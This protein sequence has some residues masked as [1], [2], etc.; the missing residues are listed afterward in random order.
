MRTCPCKG[1]AE[2]TA[3]CKLNCPK[4]YGYKEWK[5]EQE[6]WKKVRDNEKEKDNL[7]ISERA[8]REEYK[9]LKGRR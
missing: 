3:E 2:V 4:E 8:K 9:K 7:T 5:A 1:C 6:A